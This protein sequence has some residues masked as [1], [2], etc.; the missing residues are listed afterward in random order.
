MPTADVICDAS[1]AL[2]WFRSEGQE[3]VGESRALLEGHL[4]VAVLDLT[5][6][7]IANQVQADK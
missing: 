7:E 2:E 5:R 6:Y 4:T 1:V 3:E